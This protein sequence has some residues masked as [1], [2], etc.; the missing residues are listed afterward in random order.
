M[1]RDSMNTNTVVQKKIVIHEEYRGFTFNKLYIKK[2]LLN[3]MKINFRGHST[4]ILFYILW[5]SFSEYF[6]IRYLLHLC[7]K[8]YP[9]N[10]LYPP[11]ALLP[12]PPTPTPGPGIPLYWG[13]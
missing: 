1:P 13:I 2:Q 6:L 9:E 11:P 5:V 10:T 8:C 3:I 12:N 7:F 4:P